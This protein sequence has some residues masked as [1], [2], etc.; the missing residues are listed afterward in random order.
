[1]EDIMVPDIF[2]RFSKPACAEL[3][4]WQLLDGD[5]EKGWIRIGFLA[6]PE[7]CNPAGFVQGGILAAMLDDTIGP[8]VLLKSNGTLYSVTIDLRTSYLAP[9]RLGPL[10]G[11]ATVLQIGKTIGFAEGKLMDQSGATVAM[12]SSSMRLIATSKAVLQRPYIDRKLSTH[13]RKI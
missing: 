12:A 2:D 3:L 11:E 4:G 8:A 13:L 5:P 10:I 6:R 9:A 1:M 7:F